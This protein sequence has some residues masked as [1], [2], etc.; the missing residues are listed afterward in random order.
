[1]VVRPAAMTSSA[2]RN[3]LLVHQTRGLALIVFRTVPLI[4]LVALT[5]V[6]TTVGFAAED[7]VKLR[8]A[9]MKAMAAATK[10]IA[11]MFRDPGSYSSVGFGKAAAV[12]NA[13]SGEVLASHFAQGLDDQRSKAKPEIGLER[14][15]FRGLA[16]DLSDYAQALEAAA[17]ENP[18]AMTERMRMIP[19]EAMG[20]GPFGTHIQNK[21]QLASVPAEHIFHLMLQTCTTCH[22]RFRMSQ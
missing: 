13:S 8:Q 21:A 9:D 18:A 20:G 17:A 3:L 5:Y 4:S 1:M 22:A 14:E 7:L 12:I 16:N 10:T 2:R 19:G 6:L 11:D 15:R